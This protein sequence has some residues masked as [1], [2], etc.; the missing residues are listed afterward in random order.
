MNKNTILRTSAVLFAEDSKNINPTIIKR[1]MIESVFLE[2]ENKTV[3]IVQLVDYLKKFID[4]DFTEEEVIGIINSTKE[5]YFDLIPIK[6][7]SKTK[8]KLTTVRYKRVL[9]KVEDLSFDDIVDLFGKEIY[10][11]EVKFNDIKDTIHSYVYYLI[12]TNHNTLT[13]ILSGT[14][15]EGDISLCESEFVLSERD[16]INQFIN[17]DNSAKNK[18]LFALIS[19]SIEY[20]LVVNNADSDSFIESLKDKNFFLDSN[21]IYRALGINGEIR[22]KRVL[23]FLDKCKENGQVFSI[24]KHTY[25]EFTNTLKHHVKGLNKYSADKINPE[26]FERF[27]LDGDITSLYYKW[28]SDRSSGSPEMFQMYVD[29]LFK[30]FLEEYS[31]TQ[32]NKTPY[33]DSTQEHKDK[34]SDL[35][36]DIEK[37]KENGQYDLHEV[38]AENI[39]LIESLRDGNNSNLAETKIYLASTDQRLRH[40]DYTRSKFQPIVLLPS[41]W[42]SLL[43]RY[44]SRTDSDYKAFTSF[45]KLK[46]GNSSLKV[47]H[48]EHVINGISNVTNDFENQTIIADSMLEHRFDAILEGLSDEQQIEEIEQFAEKELDNQLKR[49]KEINIEDK[50]T[51]V[52]EYSAKIEKIVLEKDEALRQ[53][54]LNIELAGLE[55]LKDEKSARLKEKESSKLTMFKQKFRLDKKAEARTRLTNGL[56]LITL[57]AYIIIL[58]VL[59]NKFEFVAKYWGFFGFAYVL[60]NYVYMILRGKTVNLKKYFLELETNYQLKLYAEY[61][62]D[63]TTYDKVDKEINCLKVEIEEIKRTITMAHKA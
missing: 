22:K 23:S 63:K 17:W 4:L 21:I 10:E 50:Q 1:K 59:I 57:I 46:N 2:L 28:K 8:V 5:G 11:G 60:L 58:V 62:F 13:K 56:Y 26:I 27:H 61:G 20:C 42:M 49:Q 19:Y 52:S 51:L 37:F 44:V 32:V 15:S 3:T 7:L 31:I 18:A 24:T 16:L 14:H 55:K 41:H 35:V 6:E 38:D 33:D 54:K 40:W 43:L 45:L 12:N 25:K 48:L 9:Q 47:E 53:E 36:S 29:G 39:V 30:S 34:I